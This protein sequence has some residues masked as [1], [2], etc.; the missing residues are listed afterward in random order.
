[1]PYVHN[2]FTSKCVY[3]RNPLWLL[4]VDA[5]IGQK[6]F[7]KM[8]KNSEKKF[9]CMHLHILCSLTKFCKKKIYFGASVKKTKFYD[10]KLLFT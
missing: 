5:P 3:I 9:V 7:F 4:G 1:M 2:V 10:T 6:L 8:S